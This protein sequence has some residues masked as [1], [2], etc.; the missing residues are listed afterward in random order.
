V[1][2]ELEIIR[3][4]LRC[5]SVRISGQ[6]IVRLVQASEHALRQGLE[7]WFSPALVD[8]TEKETMAYLLECATAA[9]KLRTISPDIVFVAG[10]ELTFFM[11][12]LVE[13]KTAFDR[14]DTF[15]KPWRLL[16]ST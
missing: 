3:N 7:V 1:H 2:R 14:M 16:R 15:M 8:A 6:D 11:K 5:D 12:G 9:E 4:D 10:C 13:G